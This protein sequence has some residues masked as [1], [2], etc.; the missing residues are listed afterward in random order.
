MGE[1]LNYL[2]KDKLGRSILHKAVDNNFLS[3]VEKLLDYD[4]DPLCYDNNY[5]MP[6][7][8]AITKGYDEMAALIVSKLDN[9]V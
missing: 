8:I 6:L 4:F 9:F 5:H 1:D 2:C 7:H 3:V